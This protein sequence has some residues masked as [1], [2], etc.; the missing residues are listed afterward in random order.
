[1][2]GVTIASMIATESM[3]MDFSAAPIG[4]CGPN[5]PVVQAG[6]A[7]EHTTIAVRHPAMRNF[8]PM[9][10]IPKSRRQLN[11][12]HLVIHRTM[13][14]GEDVQMGIAHPAKWLFRQADR[15]CLV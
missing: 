9:E 2:V 11:Y 10:G 6:S 15:A 14:S 4:P 13:V 5:M 3:R 1:M 7:S 8:G 12:L